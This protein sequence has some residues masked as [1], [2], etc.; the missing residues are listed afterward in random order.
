[1]E[2]SKERNLL[3]RVANLS[4]ARETLEN[5]DMLSQSLAARI[6]RRIID[7]VRDNPGMFKI[8]SVEITQSPQPTTQSP[9]IKNRP[10]L[11]T[12]KRDLTELLLRILEELLEHSPHGEWVSLETLNQAVFPY[13]NNTDKLRASIGRLRKKIRGW[14][15]IIGKRG[16][17]Y[18]LVIINNNL[19]QT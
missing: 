13:E 9:I 15:K 12:L 18:R 16:K 8:T 3:T 2:R 7:I 6:N 11:E 19:L 4:H 10:T 5:E 1:M 14:G 17:G